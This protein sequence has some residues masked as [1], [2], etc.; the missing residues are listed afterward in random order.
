MSMTIKSI[1]DYYRDHFYAIPFEILLLSK[2]SDTQET[3]KTRRENNLKLLLA[4]KHLNEETK[5][6]A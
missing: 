6:N 4:F 1:E 5:I 2:S 3:F